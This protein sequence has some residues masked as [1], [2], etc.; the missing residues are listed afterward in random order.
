MIYCKIKVSETY[1]KGR[2]KT[3][4]KRPESYRSFSIDIFPKLKI[5]VPQIDSSMFDIWWTDVVVD[6][7]VSAGSHVFLLLS[8]VCF[9]VDQIGGR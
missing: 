1:F 9:Q 8:T 3:V 7:F 6:K 2:G 5:D 4:K